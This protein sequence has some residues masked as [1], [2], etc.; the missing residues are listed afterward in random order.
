MYP[1]RKKSSLLLVLHPTSVL[2][3]GW[4]FPVVDQLEAVISLVSANNNLEASNKVILLHCFSLEKLFWWVEISHVMMCFCF[5]LTF[6]V[7]NF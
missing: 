7:L 6:I 3:M 5:A 4:V 1:M 2:V